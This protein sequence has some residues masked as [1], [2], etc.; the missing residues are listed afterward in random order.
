MILICMAEIAVRVL[1]RVGQA[2]RT[3]TKLIEAKTIQ[4][5]TIH[6]HEAPRVAAKT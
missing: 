5:T 2:Q 3:T 6:R 4:I 1:G